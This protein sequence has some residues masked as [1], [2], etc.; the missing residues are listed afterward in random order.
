[1][2]KLAAVL[3]SAL[4]I[5]S[6]SRSFAPTEPQVV[7]ADDETAV[8]RLVLNE[9]AGEARIA[10]VIPDSTENF[11]VE[12]SDY[13]REHLPELQAET[14][15]HYNLINR[16]KHP[17]RLPGNLALKVY[18]A[19]RRDIPPIFELK[20]KFPDAKAVV[21]LSR[22]GFNADQTQA[23]V[24][25]STF[26]GPLAAVGELVLLTKTDGW[27]ITATAIVWIS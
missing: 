1:M 19:H 3:L 11:I 26:W 15:T 12:P 6:C 5:L 22:V 4:L 21:E 8:F 9:L 2:K 20:T 25:R 27:T 14:L 24:Y 17:L 18:Q 23:L 16:A 7:A 13:L 10:V